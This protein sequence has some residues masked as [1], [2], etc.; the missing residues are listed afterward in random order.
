MR[1][2]LAIIIIVP[3]L[4]IGLFMLSGK[5]IGIGATI[6]II[7]LTGI[8]GAWLAK[9]Q[10][11]EAIRRAQEQMNYGQM[12]GEAIM[13]GICILAGGIFLISPGFFTDLVGILLLIP[14]TR[15]LLKPIIGKLIQRM[16]SRGQ[17]TIIRR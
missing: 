4:E 17:F 12:P 13:D 16:L 1:L 6:A 10:G 3:A 9:K 7:L 11:I 14:Q 2:L 5:A 8:L 15:Y